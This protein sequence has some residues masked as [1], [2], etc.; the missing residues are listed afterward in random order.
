MG[1]AIRRFL[2]FR[3]GDR[4]S[5]HRQRG[6]QMAASERS[7][8]ALAPRLRRGRAGAFQRAAGALSQSGEG[9]PVFWVQEEPENM[10]AWR[11]LFTRFGGKLGKYPFSGIYR[12]ASASPA[13][14][15]A[16]RHKREQMEL[17][18]QA[19]GG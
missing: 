12:E 2:E 3:A 17:V 13:T 6:R 8:V 11:Y 5:I 9:T 16:S 4:R 10:S 18:K 19:L 14:G 15:S 1:G 7:S